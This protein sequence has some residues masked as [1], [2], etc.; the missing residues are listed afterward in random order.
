M[1]L[2][3]E[4]NDN[5]LKTKNISYLKLNTYEQGSHEN[6]EYLNSPAK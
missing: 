1:E 4:K 5:I 3:Q 6:E 2:I